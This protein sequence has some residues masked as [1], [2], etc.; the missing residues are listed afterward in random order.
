MYYV[1]FMT[2]RYNSLADVFA[3]APETIASHIARSKEFHAQGTVL[4][5]GAFLDK[6]SEPVST[7]AICT[8]RQAAED[9]ARGDPFVLNGTVSQWQIR[10]WTDL[11]ASPT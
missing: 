9:F 11:F 1:V 5:A 2:T 8:T 6:S 7:M 3:Q 4:M 10:E